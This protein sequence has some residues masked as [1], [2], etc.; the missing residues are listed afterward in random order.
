MV[1][2]DMPRAEV[3]RDE[4]A[5]RW[6]A[7]IDGAVA[8][9]AAYRLH[10]GVVV[11]THTDVDPAFEGRGVGSALARTALDEVLATG[12]LRVKPVCPFI[13]SWIDRHPSYRDLVVDDPTPV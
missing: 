3:K 6:E 2:N 1:E 12:E 7:R 10:D 9:F 13:R 5:H 4:R 8:G 11:F